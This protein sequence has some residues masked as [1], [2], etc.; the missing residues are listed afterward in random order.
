MTTYNTYQEAKIANPE[1]DIYCDDFHKCFQAIANKGCSFGNLTKCNPADYC[2][3]VE[4]FHLNGY[5]LFDGDLYELEGNVYEFGRDNS[6]S[7][8]ELNPSNKERLVLRAAA[9]EVMAQDNEAAEAKTVA[10]I[11]TD[12]NFLT[13]IMERLIH[14]HGENPNY[15]YMHRLNGIINSM[16]DAE[17]PK[18]KHTKEEYVKVTESIFDL[19]DD[20]CSGDLKFN[21]GTNEKPKY[22]TIIDITDLAH[23]LLHNN[24]YRKVVTEVTEREAFIKECKKSANLRDRDGAIEVYGD[25]FDAGCRFN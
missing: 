11:D 7:D 3:T 17:Q 9:L 18:P 14:V 19:K 8:N 20:Y 15:D 1:S 2:I 5:K 4:K 24:V 22:E 23:H 16:I 21:D 12:S 6:I 10:T 25:L 13:W